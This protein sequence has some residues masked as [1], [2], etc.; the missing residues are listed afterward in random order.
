MTDAAPQ[1]I[2]SLIWPEPGLST[3]R[4]L[5]LR[6]FGPA[7]LDEGARRV[8]LA[9]GGQVRLDTWFNL[10]ALGKWR[11]R[12]GLDSLWLSVAGAGRVEVQIHAAEG[13]APVAPVLS[14]VVSLS[15]GPA[16]IDLAR[17]LPGP[18]DDR[19]VLG[20][21]LTAL[22]DGHL[23]AVD[24][25]TADAPRRD[26]S[27]VLSV[28][29]FRREE[30]ARRAMERFS[31]F[32]Q[33]R[34]DLAGRLSMQVVD[35]GRTLPDP[36]LPHV[37]VMPN[38]NL[39]GAGGFARGL[40][41]ARDAGASHCLF[42]DDDASVHMEALTRTLTFLAHARDPRT[43]VAGAM[44]V[45]DRP[46]RLWENG[47]TFDQRCVPLHLGADLRRPSHVREIEHDAAGPTPP[48]F[49]GGWWYYAFPLDHV[50]HLPFPFFVRGDDVSFGLAHDFA[51]VTLNGVASFQDGFVAKESP[52]TWY[53]DLRSHL[54]HHLSLPHMARGRMRLVKLVAWFWARNLIRMHYETMQAVALAVED[55][56]RG[57]DWFAA[58]A[59]LAG[60]RR[61]LGALRDRE[62]WRPMDG[63]APSEHVRL[64]PD[65]A[66]VRWAMKFTLNGHLLPGFARLGNRVV[67]D[68]DSRGKV[69]EVW[70]AAEIVTVNP[71]T[72]E[73]Y[74]VRH[75][76]R[77]FWREAR[78]IAGVLRRFHAAYPRLIDEWQ[79]AYPR[80]T[81]ESFWRD[82]LDLDTTDPAGEEA[83][84]DVR[85]HAQTGT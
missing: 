74:A 77:A 18:A 14:T 17:L 19:R 33:D 63:P 80:L 37:T 31:A 13:E 52:L 57:P 51:S 43:A 73:S 46:S 41:A 54:A 3:E 25:L 50:R 16:R 35:N 78:R 20:V 11:G 7:G 70:A 32:L 59:D 23:D 12:C 47:A 55:V 44:I 64:D 42:M 40:I 8:D 62:A 4:A 5:Y 27:L 34:P 36:G 22:A 71:A 84:D 85:H 56:M 39:G 68:P 38:A 1:A 81:A 79:A 72:A 75:S 58:N 2:Q 49:Y 67:A 82:A 76:K 6:T 45:A 48:N 30:A 60:R 15:D 83:A 26:P 53:L 65:S 66:L 69:R 28:T 24:W 29:T 9:P 61:D 10:F 21:T